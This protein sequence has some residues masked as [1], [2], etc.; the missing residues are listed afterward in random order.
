MQDGLDISMKFSYLLAREKTTNANSPPCERSNPVRTLSDKVSPARGPSAV[1]M[2]VLIDISPTRRANT[3][4]HSRNNSCRT[5]NFQVANHNLLE[6]VAKGIDA[7]NTNVNIVPV[8]Q[9]LNIN[10]CASGDEEE[11]EQKATERPNVSFHLCPV[12][13][14]SE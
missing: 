7:R 12:V 9:Y 13:G 4:G 8:S 1:M 5:F 11:T 6:N 2:A 14:L 3:C 10:R